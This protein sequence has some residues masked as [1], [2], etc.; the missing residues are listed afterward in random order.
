[1][2]RTIASVIAATADA[3][4]A[5]GVDRPGTTGEIA[6][7]VPIAADA[8]VL[9]GQCDVLLDFSSPSALA[10]KL[11]AARAARGPIMI[12]TTRLLPGHHPL[13]DQAAGP[14]A[15]LPASTTPPGVHPHGQP[16]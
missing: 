5:G 12:G 16:V 11:K 6:P 15:G 3:E 9:A 2:G 1:M 10:A 14:V 13:I 8:A 4:I 7:G